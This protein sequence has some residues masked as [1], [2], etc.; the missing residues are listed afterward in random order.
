MTAPANSTRL[1]QVWSGA[2]DNARTLEEL[3]ARESQQVRARVKDA[4][5]Q[6]TYALAGSV[7][8]GLLVAV[9]SVLIEPSCALIDVPGVF[10][11]GEIPGCNLIPREVYPV[12]AITFIIGMGIYVPLRLR[13][14][15]LRASAWEKETEAYRWIRIRLERPLPEEFRL[16]VLESHVAAL[17]RTWHAVNRLRKAFEEEWSRVPGPG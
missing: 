15:E 14:V 10:Q 6:G 1:G 8:V 11:W 4:R 9:L 12:G 5:L 7:G 16:K 2:L 3:S 17:T 13:T